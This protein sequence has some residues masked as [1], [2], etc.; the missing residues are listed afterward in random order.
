MIRLDLRATFKKKG[1][2]TFSAKVPAPFWVAIARSRA[3]RD[4]SPAGC[5][6]S[7]IPPCVAGRPALG[8]HAEILPMRTR[9]VITF[10]GFPLASPRN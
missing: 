6:H 3:R 8:S 10:D 7:P 5:T 9:I 2:G 4:R 1:A